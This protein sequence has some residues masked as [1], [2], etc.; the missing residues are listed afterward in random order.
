[1]EA[2]KIKNKGESLAQL[3]ELAI[4]P[5]T[6][7]RY[8]QEPPTT[9]EN[10]L[11]DLQCFRSFEWPLLRKQ[12][13]ANWA[14]ANK[15]PLMEPKVLKA[16]IRSVMGGKIEFPYTGVVSIPAV[17]KYK[18]EVIVSGDQSISPSISLYESFQ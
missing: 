12:Y 11:F 15:S 10:M 16:G 13:A 7:D 5:E 1:M 2:L 8:K 14:A 17:R 3:A 18:V 4:S 6:I 9:F